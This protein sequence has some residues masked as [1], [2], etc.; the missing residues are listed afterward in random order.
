MNMK[1]IFA[2][3]LAGL[4]LPA[5]GEAETINGVQWLYTVSN[6][7]AVLGSG[8]DVPAVASSTPGLVRV[9][10]RLGGYP[11]TTVGR[12]AFYECKKI[13]SVMLPDTIVSIEAQAFKDCRDLISVT[14]PEGVTNI[15]SSA[16]S[17]CRDLPSVKLPDALVTVGSSAF[18][19]CH[20]LTT[21]TVPA[22]VE[23]I[24]SGAFAN[25]TNLKSIV[26]AEGN[27]NFKAVDGVLF[28][29]GGK[30][31]KA[32]P[33]GK[34]GG[35]TVPVRTEKISGSA[36]RGAKGLDAIVI[37]DT[38]EE[39]ASRAFEKCSALT[40]VRLPSSLKLIDESTFSECTALASVELPAKL[41]EIGAYAFENCTALESLALPEGLLLID[42][43]AFVGCTRLTA[44]EIP[45]SVMEIGEKAFAESGIRALSV[46]ESNT[47]YSAVD[48]MLYGDAGTALVMCPSMRTGAVTLAEGVE[49]IGAGAFAGCAGVTSVSI[50]ATVTSIGAG[51]FEGC[52]A[53]GVIIA[54]PGD[55]L[56]IKG[57]LSADAGLTSGQLARINVSE[58]MVISPVPVW[59]AA[60]VY[61]GI[62]YDDGVPAGTIQI[63][64]ARSS[65]RGVRVSGQVVLPNGKK[66]SVKA[67]YFTPDEDTLQA[68]GLIVKLMDNPLS[69]TLNATGMGG[70]LGA[71][72]V[73]G[74]RDVHGFRAGQEKTLS[75]KVLGALGGSWNVSI[76]SA[77]GGCDMFSLN[78]QARGKVRVTGVLASGAK[79]SFA[80]VLMSRESE[81]IIPLVYT[82]SATT[83]RYVLVLDNRG[84]LWGVDGADLADVAFGRPTNLT[85]EAP[86]F[87]VDA[88]LCAGLLQ[89]QT[90]ASYLP[91]RVPVTVSGSRWVLPRAGK[92]VLRNGVV[93]ESK[94]LDNPAAVK[95]TYTARTG[96]FKGSFKAYVAS[97][98]RVK[99]LSASIFG[100][101]IDG[102]GYGSATIRGKG[103]VPV[104][105]E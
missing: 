28:T 82:R 61:N 41:R 50:P 96:T 45:A 8:G 49:K 86:L 51:A 11:V 38:V 74:V 60:Q 101:V 58:G 103:A 85:S 102:R 63:K 90:Y 98:T 29:N 71:Y 13:T 21:I 9:P 84:T 92:V 70:V 89:D 5:L 32:Y 6:G 16:F 100:I 81:S 18:A 3:A 7:E 12:Q 72:E 76:P 22:K 78:V 2:V 4:L 17:G 97:G 59:G 14:I 25:C 1:S 44:L 57:L 10:A 23:D 33:A 43:N 42:D 20:S 83:V 69:L 80:S 35:Y 48:G 88:E 67:A 91:V 36:F 104:V 52:N 47:V 66:A 75:D 53:L 26:V 39:I 62:L 99:A 94:L 73:S 68:Q 34:V 55:G 37:P 64:T 27:A 40:K 77:E 56:R 93:D 54:E 79:V 31:L 65:T 95:L 105:I 15:S 24:D 19:G 87:S 46:A 30:K